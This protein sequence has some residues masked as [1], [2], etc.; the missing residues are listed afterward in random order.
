[1]DIRI[2]KAPI[3]FVE[4]E[5][6]A[7]EQFGDVIKAVVDVEQGVMALGPEMHAE[8]ETL[9]MEQE[10]SKRE[11]TWGINLYP[12]KRGEDFLEF[13]SMINLKPAQGN[14]SRDI[15]DATVRAKII[16]IVGKLVQ[17]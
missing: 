4:V 2:V 1:M 8:G 3:P 9:L 7:L 5:H 13:D 12:A 10:G 15:E 14:R 17:K 6:V 16:A 11:H